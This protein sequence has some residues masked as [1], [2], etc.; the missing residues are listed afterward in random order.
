M[1]VCEREPHHSLYTFLTVP[2]GIVAVQKQE[3]DKNDKVKR[4]VLVV[5]RWLS[6]TI[7]KNVDVSDRKLFKSK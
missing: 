3:V 5:V 6:S 7:R 1:R 2:Q 4:N